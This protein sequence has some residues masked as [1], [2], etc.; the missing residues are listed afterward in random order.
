MYK[1]KLNTQRG[2]IIIIFFRIKFALLELYCK[3]MKCFKGRLFIIFV[4]NVFHNSHLIQKCI[5]NQQQLMI[6]Y[7]FLKQMRVVKN[8]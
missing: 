8:I 6:L 2:K 7:T 5:Q 4:S 1:K 3:Y